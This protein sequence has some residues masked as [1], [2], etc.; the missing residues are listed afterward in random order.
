MK[1]LFLL[2]GLV[3]LSV[4]AAA[5]DSRPAQQQR[6]SL[7][8]APAVVMARVKPGQGW[9]QTL[10]MS[11]G[12]AVPFRFEVEVQDVVVKNGVRTYVPAGETEGGIAVSAVSTPRSIVVPPQTEGSATVTL[13]LPQGTR[14][15]AVVIYFR[16]KTDAPEPG[17]VGLGASLGALITFGLS[18]DYNVEASGF[19]TTA[20]SDS[21]NQV[22]SHQLRNTGAEV[23]VPKGAAAILDDAGH[24]IAKATYDSRRLLP[25]EVLTFTAV[26]PAQLKPGHYRV[27]SSFEFEGHVV[28]TGGEFSVP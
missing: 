26:C 12:T 10:R 27:V 7:T 24:R 19:A 4:I 20:Q 9:T 5:D 1:Y 11:N 15:R 6:P 16:G 28:T 17:S 8:L 25:G 14:Q 2:C 13:T 21:A 23:V 3:S 22:I 18:D